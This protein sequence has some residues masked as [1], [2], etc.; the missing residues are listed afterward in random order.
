MLAG[1]SAPRAVSRPGAPEWGRG[2]DDREVA[3]TL[4]APVDRLARDLGLRAPSAA[5]HP[6]AGCLGR[7]HEPQRQL[8]HHRKVPS[9]PQ[10]R[11]RKS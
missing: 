4:V 3:T 10:S 9:L 7:G 5:S 11:R 6:V 1:R 2:H 8:G